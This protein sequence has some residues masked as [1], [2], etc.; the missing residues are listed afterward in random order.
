[1]DENKYE[2]RKK[3]ATYGL[4]IGGVAMIVLAIMAYFTSQFVMMGFMAVNG[5]VLLCLSYVSGAIFH[6]L[7][8]I[9]EKEEHN[10]E[11]L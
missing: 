11:K 2:N 5:L 9:K 3:M 8:L 4:L 10:E 1:M 7:D 6:K